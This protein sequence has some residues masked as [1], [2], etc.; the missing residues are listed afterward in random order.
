MSRAIRP[1]AVRPRPLLVAT[2]TAGLLLAACGDDEDEDA[3]S[4]ASQET[5]TTVESAPDDDQA[6]EEEEE[7]TEDGPAAAGE[8]LEVE[9]LDYAFAGL[10]ASVPAGTKLSFT[11]SSEVELHELVAMRLPDSEQRPVAELLALPEEELMGLFP[12][13][14]A[15][16]LMAPPAGGEQIAA[17]GDGTLEEPGRY[18]L[19]CFIPTGADPVAYMEQSGPDGPPD[20]PGGPPHV[21]HG[22]FAELVVE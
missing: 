6:T 16:V 13:P 15:T 3:S 8:V 4:A 7:P 14:P 9:A 19:V 12:G 21:A 20:V 10:P 1:R 2:L 18:A 22:M 17:V 11:N 5:T